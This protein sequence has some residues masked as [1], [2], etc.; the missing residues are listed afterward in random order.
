MQNQ[1]YLLTKFV[2]A[3]LNSNTNGNDETLFS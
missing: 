3:R 2:T 1:K